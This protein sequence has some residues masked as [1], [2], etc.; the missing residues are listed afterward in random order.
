MTKRF[1]GEGVDL[2]ADVKIVETRLEHERHGIL[3]ENIRSGFGG[4]DQQLMHPAPRSVVPDRDRR[5]K[6]KARF[7]CRGAVVDHVARQNQSVGNGYVHVLDGPDAGDEQGFL[8]HVA[9]GV[10][11][12]HPIPQLKAARV[13]ENKDARHHVGNRRTRTRER[14]S[15]TKIEMPWKAGDF[16]PGR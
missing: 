6:D 9:S 10:A 11:D 5:V 4:L 14:R 3:Q 7:L 13:G 8:H 16:E 2:V 15:P 12:F 1:V